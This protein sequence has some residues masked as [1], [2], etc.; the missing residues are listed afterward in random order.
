MST[1]QTTAQSSQKLVV[2]FLISSGLLLFSALLFSPNLLRSRIA[3]DQS[4]Q[5]A[6]LRQMYDSTL[7]QESQSPRTA[8]VSL[9]REAPTAA[10]QGASASGAGQVSFAAADRKIVRTSAIELTVNS[11]ANAAEQ[12]RLITEALGGY[13]EAE[14]IGGT[15]EVP[16]AD[17]TIRVPAS[18]FEST[19]A[20]IRKLAARIEAEKTDA[21]D[22][23]RQYVDMEARLRNLRAEEAQYLVIMKSADKVD[24]LLAVSQKLSEVRGEIERQ[25]AE[26]QALSKQ[27]ETVAITVAL[28]P[29]SDAQAWGFN[30]RPLYR[31]KVATRDGIDALADYAIAMVAIL[32][33]V[34]VVLAWG[35][36]ILLA[37]LAGWRT[38]RWVARRFV[39]GPTSSPGVAVSN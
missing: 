17:L 5:A 25:Q 10:A 11:P 34:P 26:F 39:D 15:K 29:I 13:L 32:F 23:T 35:I 2:T 28:R 6:T 8:S 3:A 1:L 14:Q 31:L 16:V 19:K 22:V 30:W 36:T 20:A 21:Q 4:K 33:Y 27:V 12:I 18:Q 38:Y 9:E 37:V 24:D 7:P